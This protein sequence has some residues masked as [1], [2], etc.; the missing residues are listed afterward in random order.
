VQQV[1]VVHE[2]QAQ[3]A[4]RPATRSSTAQAASTTSGPIP[5]TPM[6]TIPAMPMLPAS[7]SLQATND[8]AR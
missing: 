4:G 5:S 1:A 3:P 6:T 2:V 8:G 7:E